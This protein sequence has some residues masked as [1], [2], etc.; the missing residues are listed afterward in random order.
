MNEHDKDR[1]DAIELSLD[2]KAWAYDT[3]KDG[4]RISL[5]GHAAN[6]L[7]SAI[8]E[9]D[10]PGIVE[11]PKRVAKFWYEATRGLRCDPS[12]LLKEFPDEGGNYN[13]MVVQ[14]A[15]PFYS[16]CEHHLVPFF[17]TASVAYVPDGKIVGLS[18]LARYVREVA[19]K[20][21]VQERL[22]Q[23]IANGL[24]DALSPRGVAVVVK[25]RHLCMEMR[26]LS[27][28]GIE[29]VTS[30]MIGVMFDEPSAR[31]EFFNLAGER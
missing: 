5:A 24:N 14:R 8:G 18:K 16:M 1:F 3:T 17:G 2:R 23:E 27:L 15:I 26:G 29:T 11:T 28:P 22:T 21:Q 20:P 7:L 10:R 9:T 12:S 25:A 6:N 30:K 19:A 31:A 13:E 4:F